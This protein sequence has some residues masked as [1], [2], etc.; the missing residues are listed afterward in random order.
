MGTTTD[1]CTA[2]RTSGPSAGTTTTC[3]FPITVNDVAGAVDHGADGQPELRCGRRTTRWR[4][5]TVAY[6]AADNCTAAVAITCALSVASNEP[7]NG[8]GDGDTAPDWL[9]VNAHLVQLRAERS[10][11]GT[12]RIYT[13]TVTCTDQAGR[14]LQPDGD[15]ERAAQPVGGSKQRSRPAPGGLGGGAVFLSRG[16]W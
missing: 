7:I 6:S 4:T 15:G 1:V 13:V 10:G 2:T 9:V 5:C 16:T 14:Q 3:S 8:L 12:G 11:T